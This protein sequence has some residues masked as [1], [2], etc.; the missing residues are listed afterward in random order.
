MTAADLIKRFEG[1][2]LTAYPDPGTGA[3]PYTVGWGCTGPGIGPGTVWTQAQADAALEHRL[4]SVET[5]VKGLAPDATHNEL[6]ALCSFAWNVG[7]H[8]LARSSLLAALN[9]GD[10]VTAGDKF[11]QWTIAGGRVMQGLVNRRTAERA[12]FLTPDV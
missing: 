7:T 11:M 1:C 4:A 2:R 6:A 12:L 5:V 8:A 9:A 3:A 10:P